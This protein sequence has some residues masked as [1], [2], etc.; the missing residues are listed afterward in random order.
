MSKLPRSTGLASSPDKLR[1]ADAAA[2]VLPAMQRWLQ[3]AV[4]GLNL[5][6]FAKAVH[7]KGQIRWVVCDATTP[8]A[9]LHS[10]ISELHHLA[11]TLA[12]AFLQGNPRSPYAQRLRSLLPGASDLPPP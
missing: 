11:T 8:E 10:L 9:L 6:P 2:E 1:D 5:C 4:I 12:R 3:R 7:S